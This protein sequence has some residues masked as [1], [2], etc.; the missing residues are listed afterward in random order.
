MTKALAVALTAVASLVAACGGVSDDVENRLPAWV[1]DSRVVAF[2]ITPEVV[3]CDDREYFGADMELDPTDPENGGV[4]LSCVWT[5]AEYHGEV[6]R[7]TLRVPVDAGHHWVEE[8][9]EL[10]RDD[11]WSS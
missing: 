5:C 3:V 8:L 4:L 2:S 10:E 7:W 9:A 11:C 1:T 6:G